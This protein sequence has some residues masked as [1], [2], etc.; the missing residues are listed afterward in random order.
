MEHGIVLPHF[1]ARY[2]LE[3]RDRLR[4]NSHN[5][6]R[7]YGCRDCGTRTR[8]YDRYEHDIEYHNLTPPSPFAS[9]TTILKMLE[10]LKAIFGE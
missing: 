5:Y 7:I 3:T 2:Y 9:Q 1:S 8:F 10:T 4:N 6:P